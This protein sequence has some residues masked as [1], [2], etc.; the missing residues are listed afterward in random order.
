MN[1]HRP[2][3][4]SSGTS[5]AA[6][7]YFWAI[8]FLGLFIFLKHDYLPFVTFSNDYQRFTSSKRVTFSRINILLFCLTVSEEN[9]KAAENTEATCVELQRQLIRQELEQNTPNIDGAHASVTH[10]ICSYC[11][12]NPCVLS[13]QNLPAR[14][15]AFG[16]P[17]MT[18]HIKRKG[19]YKSFYTILNRRGLWRDPIYIA[20]KE[21]L[22][23]YV[24]DV[25]EVMPVCVVEDVRKR[26]PNPD[27]VP[28][29]GHRR[30]E[31]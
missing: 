10:E 13:S 31:N 21:A 30:S 29:C 18:N 9:E 16:Q 11:R 26:W 6:D 19:D 2:H 1:I 17:R 23:C 15:T 27:G 20:R 22:G 7:K 14:L 5:T 3:L 4:Q 12:S 28:Y 24:E 8:F 25:R